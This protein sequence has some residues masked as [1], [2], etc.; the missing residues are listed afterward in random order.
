MRF[1]CP[2]LESLPSYAWVPLRV[3]AGLGM[4]THGWPKLFEPGRWERF[5]DSVERMGF[6][7]PEFFAAAAALSELIGGALLALG[8]ATRPA[9]AFILITMTVAAFW[10]HAGDPFA[11][12]ELA[13]LYL[14]VALGFLLYGGGRYSLDAWMAKRSRSK[15]KVGA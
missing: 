4:M 7:V 13:L 15:A 1:A 5:V 2:I 10:R 9:A 12:R 11:E 3:L 6:P 8:L 14:F